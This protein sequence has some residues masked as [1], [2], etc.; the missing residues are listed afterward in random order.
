MH[1]TMLDRA[2]L[3]AVRLEPHNPDLIL[4]VGMRVLERRVGGAVS[5][6]R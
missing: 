2:A 1:D 3:H 5:R 6:P 4:G